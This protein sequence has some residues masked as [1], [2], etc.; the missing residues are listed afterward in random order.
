MRR[1]TAAAATIALAATTLLT[2]CAQE[3]KPAAA[4]SSKPSVFQMTGDFTLEQGQFGWEANEC[5][6]RGGYADLAVGAQVVVTGET[7]QTLALGSIVGSFAVPDPDDTSGG[8]APTSC[9]LSIRVLNVPAGHKFYGVEVSHR[10]VVQFTEAE[11]RQSV[12]LNIG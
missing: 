6:G 3:A 8:G 2:G 7:Q 11:A 9:T 12:K 4:A 10:G 1:T 5:T